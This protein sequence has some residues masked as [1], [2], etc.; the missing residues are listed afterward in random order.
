MPV[1][2]STDPV[3]T[4]NIN[5]TTVPLRG[6]D[7]ESTRS[8]E[9]SGETEVPVACKDSGTEKAEDPVGKSTVI[10]PVLILY[11]SPS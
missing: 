7:A 2:G 5:G 1:L 9:T 10:M 3:L 8:Y 6:P 4:G 11:H